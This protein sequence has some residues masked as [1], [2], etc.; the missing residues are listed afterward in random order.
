MGHATDSSRSAVVARD[1]H[2]APILDL[3]GVITRTAVATACLPDPDGVQALLEM[4][5]RL[6]EERR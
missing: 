4:L 6:P 5:A 2:D 1:R 3:D